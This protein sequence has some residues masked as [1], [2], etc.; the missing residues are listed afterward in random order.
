MKFYLLSVINLLKLSMQDHNVANRFL[1]D[2]YNK[3][4]LRNLVSD[5]HKIDM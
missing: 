3:G 2:N 1:Q 4:T 5:I